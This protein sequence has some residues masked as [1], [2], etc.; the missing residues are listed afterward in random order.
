MKR[1]VV[2]QTRISEP[3]R[4]QINRRNPD[5]MKYF[6]ASCN[7]FDGNYKKAND[8]CMYVRAGVIRADQLEDVYRIG[9]I[10]PL[11]QIVENNRLR[12]VSVGD[13]VV[14]EDT[15]EKFFCASFGWEPVTE[16]INDYVEWK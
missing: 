2:Y 1:Y 16:K 3:L 13:I 8:L 10:G 7:Q 14:D 9:N 5:A 4:A 6:D 11:D 15:G 12:S